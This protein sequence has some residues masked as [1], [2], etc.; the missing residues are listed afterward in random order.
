MFIAFAPFESPEVVVTVILEN[1]GGGSRNA[2]P[3]ARKLF[4][5]YFNNRVTP[6][7]TP[8]VEP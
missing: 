5:E 8:I 1:V 6:A 2:A 7:P 4:D 3:I